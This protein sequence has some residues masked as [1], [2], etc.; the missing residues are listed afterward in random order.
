M[1]DSIREAMRI[2]QAKREPSPSQP[3][4]SHVKEQG[5]GRR[6]SVEPTGTGLPL[7]LAESVDPGDPGPTDA[8]GCTKRG[9]QGHEVLERLTELA[10]SRERPGLEDEAIADYRAKKGAPPPG[11]STWNGADWHTDGG[12]IVRSGEPS[13]KPESWRD[14]PRRYDG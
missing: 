3:S 10:S 4:L 8:T 9:G 13:R 1:A 2:A 7:D 5:A 6:S 11:S 12:G 14:N